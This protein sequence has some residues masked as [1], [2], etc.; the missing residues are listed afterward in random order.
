[1]DDIAELNVQRFFQFH[2]VTGSYFG[3]YFFVFFV[4]QEKN[5]L[6]H[7]CIG[8]IVTAVCYT[9]NSNSAAN[10]SFLDCVCVC[11]RLIS[12]LSTAILTALRAHR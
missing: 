8:L 5:L 4:L 9:H 7:K 11:R 12:L 2:P 1:M 3:S 10:V 6:F